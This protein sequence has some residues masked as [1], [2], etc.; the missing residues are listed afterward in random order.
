MDLAEITA[1][2]E[3]VEI[4]ADTRLEAIGQMVDAVDWCDP[5]FQTNELIAAIERREAAAQTVVAAGFAIPHAMVKWSGRFRLVVGRSRPGIA[6]GIPGTD[7]VHLVALLVVSRDHPELHLP[8]LAA[9]ADLFRS[10]DFREAI[11]A[12]PD[13]AAIK[14]IVQQRVSPSGG[15]IPSISSQPPRLNAVLIRQAVALA[16]SLSAQALLLAVDRLD[17]VP[18]NMLVDWQGKL[19]IVASDTAEGVAIRRPHTHVF[20]IPSSGLSRLDRANLGLLLAA[21]SGVLE[22]NAWVV[23]VAGPQGAQLDSLTVVR[24]EPHWHRMFSGHCG[25][26]RSSIRPEVLLRLLSLAIELATE[27]R[28]GRPIGTMFVVGDSDCVTQYARQMVLNPFHG[29]DAALRNVLDPS[30][31]ETIKE[32]ALID[33]AFVVQ[34]DGVVLSAG[35]YLAPKAS[36][37]PLPPGLGTRHSTAAAITACTAAIAVTI[38]QSTGTVTVFREGDIVLKLE[39]AEKTRW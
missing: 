21:A 27:G 18:W 37:T 30:L 34:S 36:V 6:F 31:A 39:R 10:D 13:V 23:C 19:L 32:F 9:V 5:D 7:L 14:R 12:A 8:V 24:P 38:S 22:E 3:V 2:I 35:T 17:N 1:A 26:D 28:E 11:V 29:Y 33:G 25:S 15:Q 16:D 20:D 4:S